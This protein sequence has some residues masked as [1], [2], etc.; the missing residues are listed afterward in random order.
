MRPMRPGQPDELGFTLIEVL[1][2]TVIFGLIA[3]GVTAAIILFFRT[4]DGTSSRLALSH[5]SQLLATYLIPD[6]DNLTAVGSSHLTVKTPTGE[7]VSSVSRISSDSSDPDSSCRIP[8]ESSFSD[9]QI[10]YTE[11]N[12][13]DIYLVDY[14]VSGPVITRTVYRN[15]VKQSTIQ[16]V[17]NLS[18]PDSACFSSATGP[19]PWTMTVT[20]APPRVDC[21]KDP[22]DCYTFSVTGGGRVVTPPATKPPALCLTCASPPLVSLDTNGDGKINEIIATFDQPL[23]PDDPAGISQWGLVNAPPGVGLNSVSL[24]G[25]TATLTLIG[26]STIDTVDRLLAVTLTPDPNGGGI[27]NGRNQQASFG[28]AGVTDGMA[29]VP[30]S[31]VSGDTNSNGKVD[32]I[33][34][35][36]SENLGCPVAAMGCASPLL[37][38]V[39][40]QPG[41]PGSVNPKSV[42]LSGDTATLTLNETT[43]V[44]TVA[45]GMTVSLTRDPA[46]IQDARFNQ[47]SFGPAPVTDGMGPA[48]ISVVS[49]DTN[50]NGKVDQIVVTFSEV[51]APYTAGMTPPWTLQPAGLTVSGVTVAGT[52]ATL[53]VTGATTVDT[54]GAS[55]RLSLAA[56]SA[57]IRSKAT[58][59]LSSFGP[60][61]VSDGMGPVVV[62]L[63][64]T[65]GGTAGKLEPGDTLTL[66]F[67]EP[68]TPSSLP[69][70]LTTTLTVAPGSGN[71]DDTLS[72]I[73]LG[74][75]DLGTEGGYPQ[76]AGIQ[77]AA[78]LQI[79]GN[80]VK[81]TVG[82][83][84]GTATN[85]PTVTENHRMTVTPDNTV[86]DVAN[87][88]A[89]GKF[90]TSPMVLF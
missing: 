67:S 45:A 63:T 42:S 38:T 11:V 51:L 89:D 83:N 10:T 34:V 35:K 31:I 80:D 44:D 64:S 41:Q 66:T 8:G 58:G 84:T 40:G 52:M 78:T 14:L 29:P 46:G 49:N 32:Q 17:H 85:L 13:Q 39:T 77:F 69:P 54:V 56:N 19:A 60:T 82:A 27:R 4:T 30:L 33:K 76:N 62:G 37:W 48:P 16:V 36:F 6:L 86:I 43:T 20:T 61:V 47:S 87:N 74:S 5:D 53:S 2:S 59:N 90:T 12:S 21:A 24:W 72:I 23:K 81:V 57:G 68:V 7:S 22:V 88:P 71:A 25:N 9:L 70:N 18:S 1:I 26:G 75:I 15:S 73:G 50:G 28:P 55:L 65:N 3:S 79:T